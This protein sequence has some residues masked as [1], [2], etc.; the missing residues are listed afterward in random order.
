MFAFRGGE[1]LYAGKDRADAQ[2]EEIHT[3]CPQGLGRPPASARGIPRFSSH[4]LARCAGCA[5]VLACRF[6]PC[7]LTIRQLMATLPGVPA[8]VHSAWRFDFC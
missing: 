3:K 8:R 1:Q 4:A 2:L 7:A 5:G 6:P